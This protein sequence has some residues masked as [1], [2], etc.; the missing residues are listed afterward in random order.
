MFHIVLGLPWLIVVL[1]WLA[2]LPW[3]ISIKIV[4]AGILL[5]GSQHLLINR[6]SSGSIFDPEYPRPWIIVLNVLFGAMVFLAVMQILLD[7]ICLGPLP[8]LGYFPSVPPQLRYGMAGIALALASWGVA[9]AIRVPA[10]RN[11]E[12]AINGLPSEFDGYRILQ[13]TDLHLSRLFP[14]SWAEAVVAKSNALNPD[15]TVVTGDFIDGG[16]EAR[17]DDIAPLAGL[18]APDGVLGIPGNHEY[19]FGYD[20]WMKHDIGLG[21]RMLTNTHVVIV[22]GQS[23]IV[24][25]GVTDLASVGSKYPAPDLASALSGAPA[26]AKVI[27]LEHQPRMAER[28]AQAG[29]ALQLSGHTHGG[30]VLGL[31]RLV[32]RANNGFVS[33]LYQVGGMKLYVNNGTA[34]WP[35]FALR[36]GRPSE[37]TVFT[38]KPSSVTKETAP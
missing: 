6:L 34:L 12:I 4:V 38:L 13:L 26:G 9:Q 23:S 5:V 37:L 2:P 14:R 29:V 24:V 30:M 28:S 8:L 31:D 22:R 33:R 1:R 19:F 15:L 3:D 7:A 20:E 32:A 16:I 11:V 36:L 35:G 25:A 18:R 10:L 17:R 21:I 27:L